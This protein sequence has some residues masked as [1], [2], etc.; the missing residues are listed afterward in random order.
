MCEEEGGG[1]K[2]DT[3]QLRVRMRKKEKRR[4][5]LERRN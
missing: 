4:S 3:N 1:K 5:E 2:G